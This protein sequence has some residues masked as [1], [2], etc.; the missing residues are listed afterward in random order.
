MKNSLRLLL[1]LTLTILSLPTLAQEKAR[2]KV[3]DTDPTWIKTTPPLT[4]VLTQFDAKES[5]GIRQMEAIWVVGE[6]QFRL[7]IYLRDTNLY[8]LVFNDHRTEMQFVW[9]EDKSGTANEKPLPQGLE[10]TWIAFAKELRGRYQILNDGM[11]VET[12]P[13]KYLGKIE[14]FTDGV[15]LEKYLFR[16]SAGKYRVEDEGYFIGEVPQPDEVVYLGSNGNKQF[17]VEKK[18]EK[19]LLSAEV[20]TGL[21]WDRKER[22]RGFPVATPRAVEANK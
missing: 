7:S 15:I 3:A 6:D 9:H 21:E 14:H 19:F 4:N 2:E 18:G 8:T 17:V 1:V 13:V 12:S 16:D 10:K 5:E 11:F 22:E 20:F